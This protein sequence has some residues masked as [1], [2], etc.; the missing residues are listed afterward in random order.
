MIRNEQDIYT[1]EFR[2][3]ILY[4]GYVNLYK[5]EKLYKKIEC[6]N[7]KLINPPKFNCLLLEGKNKFLNN[8]IFN[9]LYL[10]YEF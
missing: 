5:R 1:K 6:K 7:K 10:I 9:I 2:N 8:I 4:F 3:E